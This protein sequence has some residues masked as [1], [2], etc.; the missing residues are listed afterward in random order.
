MSFF[1]RLLTSLKIRNRPILDIVFLH[2]HKTGGKSISRILSEKYGSTYARVNRAHLKRNH[3]D[4]LVPGILDFSS[5]TK[6]LAGH[7]R[8]QEVRHLLTSETKLITWL[9]HPVDR[10]ISNYYWDIKRFEEGKTDTKPSPS[11]EEYAM[12]SEHQNW[13]TYFLDGLKL[14]DIYFIGLLETIDNDL[15]HMS[16]MLGWSDY[17]LHHINRNQL[18]SK[19]KPGVTKLQRELIASLNQS[20]MQLYEEAKLLRKHGDPL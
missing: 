5:N 13:M 12:Q 11:L 16:E 9:R 3:I 14:E 20:D 15:S 10:V 7:L 18:S 17:D 8:F 4:K 19:S 2:I 1:S 6:V